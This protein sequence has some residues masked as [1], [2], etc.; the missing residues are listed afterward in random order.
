M[1]FLETLSASFRAYLQTHARSN[2]K[3]K[4]LHAKIAQDFSAKLGSEFSIFALGV[5]E[6]IEKN[7]NGAL[8]RKK[9]GYF[10]F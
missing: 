3:L 1:E 8:L 7:H 2:E 9:G 10:N 5:G 4:I 6:G